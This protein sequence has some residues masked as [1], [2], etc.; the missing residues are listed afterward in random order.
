MTSKQANIALL[1]LCLASLSLCDQIVSN[2]VWSDYCCSKCSER[3]VLPNPYAGDIFKGKIGELA[4]NGTT[5]I[6]SLIR[7]LSKM[8]EYYTTEMT[9]LLH[10]FELMTKLGVYGCSANPADDQISY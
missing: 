10:D 5:D 6:S 1:L 9:S 7:Q 3:N 4:A 8:P 2:T